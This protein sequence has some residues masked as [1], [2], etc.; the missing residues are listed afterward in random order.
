MQM[1]THGRSAGGGRGDAVEL[2]DVDVADRRGEDVHRHA[3]MDV[4]PATGPAGSPSSRFS[5]H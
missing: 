5:A 2:V 3:A 1:P 4:D